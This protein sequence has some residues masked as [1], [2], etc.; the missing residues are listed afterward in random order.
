MKSALV[1]KKKKSTNIYKERK[2]EKK[3]LIFSININSRV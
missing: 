1:E 3:E 2:K